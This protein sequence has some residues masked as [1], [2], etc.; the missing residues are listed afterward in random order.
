MTQETEKQRRER[1]IFRAFAEVA[2]FKVL[3]GSIESRTPPEPDILCHIE[4]HGAVGFELTE[5]IDQAYMDC[6]GLMFKT[7]QYLTNY[8]QSELGTTNSALFRDKY[9]DALLHFEY[10][11]ATSLKER[12]VAA[13]KALPKLL[14]LPH[15]SDGELLKS[16]PE[17]APV[18]QW[19]Q[20]T[21]I[22]ITEPIIDVSS[23]ARLG[24]PTAQAIRKK[25]LNTYK[26]DCPIELLTHINWGI[27]PHEEVWKNAA[28]NAVSQISGSPF[29]KVWV[30]DTTDKKIKYE[31]ASH[32]AQ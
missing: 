29:R 7:K 10:A 31:S 4:N 15:N 25:F 6:I 30:F 26:C 18:L 20:I 27:M 8:W 11:P 14:N 5:L 12:K 32:S 24:D 2:P 1:E 17:L 13:K 22:G 19:V 9:S 16:D 3:P 23:Y 21:R 28:D